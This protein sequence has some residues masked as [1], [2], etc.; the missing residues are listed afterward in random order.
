M[1]F[2]DFFQCFESD[3]EFVNLEINLREHKILDYQLSK[4]NHTVDFTK[5]LKCH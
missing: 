2:L 1:V 3:Q 5:I 4:K